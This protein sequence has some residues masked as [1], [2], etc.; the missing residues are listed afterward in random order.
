MVSA[1]GRD[2]APLYGVVI[3]GPPRGSWIIAQLAREPGIEM[4][5]VDRHRAGKQRR[6]DEQM[7]EYLRLIVANKG[8]GSLFLHQP[9]QIGQWYFSRSAFENRQRVVRAF[10]WLP[11]G[12]VI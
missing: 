3:R 4:Q 12:K 7:I 11:T 9:Q 2:E 1:R 5:N 6:A 8:K 10:S